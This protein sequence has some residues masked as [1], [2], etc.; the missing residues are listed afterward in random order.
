MTK[1]NSATSTH[2][3]CVKRLV[4]GKNVN[5]AED[6]AILGLHGVGPVRQPLLPHLVLY[7]TLDQEL[8]LRLGAR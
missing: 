1:H 7:V 2:L 3:W 6:E 5:D 8:C 4:I